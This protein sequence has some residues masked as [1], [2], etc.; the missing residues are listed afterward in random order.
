MAKQE[1]EHSRYPSRYGGGFVT[2]QQILAEVMCERQAAKE[3]TS[4][5]AKFWD[6]PRWNKTFLMQLRLAVKLLQKHPPTVLSRAIRTKD[7]QKAYSFGSPFL[8]DVIAREQ[9]KYD[10]EMASLAAIPPPP[11]PE[12][13]TET[14]TPRPAFVPRRSLKSK[15]E[16]L[17]RE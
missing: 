11:A 3:K 7:G 8:K 13:T 5:P 12:T 4:L 10:A 16:D 6:L 15:L 17:E 2:P 14:T 9:E 1:S